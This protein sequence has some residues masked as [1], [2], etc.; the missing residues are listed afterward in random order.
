VRL[1]NQKGL[2]GISQS[3]VRDLKLNQ[4]VR[5]IFWKLWFSKAFNPQTLGYKMSSG[6]TLYQT[7]RLIN[8]K[9]VIFILAAART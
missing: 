6:C 2:I 4:R 9:T 3:P 8:Q 1:H 5:R 7:T